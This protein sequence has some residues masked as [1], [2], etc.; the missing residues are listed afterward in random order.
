[1]RAFVKRLVVAFL[2]CGTSPGWAQGAGDALRIGVLNN[3]TGGLSAPAGPG[4]VVAAQMA[5]DDFGGTVAGRPVRL[6][7]AD[8]QNKPDVGLGI[9]RQWF[10]QGVSLIVDLPNTAVAL[11]VQKLAAEQGRIAIVVTAAG[12]SLTGRDCTPNSVAWAYNSYALAGVVGRAVVAQGG[13]TWFLL[14]T[15]YTFGRE[16][17]A[18]LKAVLGQQHATLLGTVAAPQETADFSAFLLQAQASG[19]KVLGLANVA[20]DTINSI[21]QAHEFGLVAG[22]V[23]LAT[24]LF[25]ITDVHSLGLETAGGLYLATAFYWDRT[26]EARAWSQRFFAK[27]GAMPSMLQ[28]GVYS[29]V[30]HYLQA[31]AAAK[32]DAAGP[33]MAQMRAA[34]VNDMFAQGGHIREDGLMVH[35]MYLAQVKTPAESHGPWDYLKIILTVPGDEAFGPLSASKCPLLKKDAP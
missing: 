33:V 16:M 17:E 15:D 12:S 34:P 20:A 8:E 5:I 6:V 30:T 4:S 35:D 10:D 25:T 9:A 28:A 21:K 26:P 2:V 1:M 14:S 11:A 23:K 7:S 27:H 29:A 18:D 3:A 19:A 24:L 13:D 32:T 22:G 31:V